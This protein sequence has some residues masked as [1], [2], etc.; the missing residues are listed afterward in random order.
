MFAGIVLERIDACA[1]SERGF[2]VVEVL[3]SALIV[4][5]LAAAVASALVG[6]AKFSGNER[7]RSQADGSRAAGPGAAAGSLGPRI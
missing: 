6:T 3:A 7:Q 2:S 1:A 4:A 5:V